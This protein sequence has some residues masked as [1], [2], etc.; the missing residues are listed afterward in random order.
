MRTFIIIILPFRH[1]SVRTRGFL[2]NNYYSTII[3]KI[4]TLI[5]A[6]YNYSGNTYFT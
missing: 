6:I 2:Y 4:I 1:L 3:I 5:I